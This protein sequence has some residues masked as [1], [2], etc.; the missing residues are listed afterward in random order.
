MSHTSVLCVSHTPVPGVSHNLSLVC[1][2][3]LF[4]VCP[5]HLSLMCPIHLSL[6]CPKPDHDVSHTLVAAV[7]PTPLCGTVC[8]TH[9][10]LPCPLHLFVALCV[11]H[12]CGCCVPYTS[13][14][15]CVSHTL[16][17]AVSPT[18]LCGTVCP[19]H[20]WLL[21]SFFFFHSCV[22][23]TCPCCVP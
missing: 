12:T 7:S 17:A 15:H 23:H 9:L 2:I 1:P 8:P 14:W 18:P 6:V 22:L 13:L 4:L 3:Y 5:I 19:T 20:L 21:C 16:V 10:W 11:P